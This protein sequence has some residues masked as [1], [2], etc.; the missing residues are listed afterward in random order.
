MKMKRKL[1]IPSNYQEIDPIYG[2]LIYVLNS[3]SIE[4]IFHSFFLLL[5]GLFMF[6]RSSDMIFP[7]F[8]C[9]LGLMLITTS[10][11]LFLIII[12]DKM[13]FYEYGVVQNSIFSHNNPSFLYDDMECIEE[14]HRLNRKKKKASFQTYYHFIVKPNTTVFTFEEKEYRHCK[15]IVKQVKDHLNL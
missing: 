1:N 5:L 12:F 10:I 2:K 9:I 8:S 13:K 11:Y 3:H 14:E 6:L 15:K 4:Q 7:L